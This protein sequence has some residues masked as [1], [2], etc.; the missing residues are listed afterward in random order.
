MKTYI[1][2]ILNHVICNSS[3]SPKAT[4]KLN[5][6]KFDNQTVGTVICKGKVKKKTAQ[7]ILRQVF[8]YFTEMG[9]SFSGPAKD[10]S[11]KKNESNG[12]ADHDEGKKLPTTP[13]M[14]GDGPFITQQSGAQEATVYGNNACII[15]RTGVQVCLVERNYGPLF[16]QT[17][18][19]QQ[20]DASSQT[21]CE[22]A[23][24]LLTLHFTGLVC[25]CTHFIF[26]L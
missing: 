26:L 3:L 2:T 5:N 23:P 24:P 19:V 21:Y 1:S 11:D 18:Y 25:C 20:R 6:K 4:I 15:Q 17:N 8:Y 7:R 9:N 10:P 12:H 22:T 16:L 13:S 14:N